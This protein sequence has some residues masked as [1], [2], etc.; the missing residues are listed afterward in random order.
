MSM[1][2]PESEGDDEPTLPNDSHGKLKKPKKKGAKTVQ[3][4]AA[5]TKNTNPLYNYPRSIQL[6]LLKIESHRRNPPI[7]SSSPH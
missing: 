4:I 2:Q 5:S 6:H 7:K 1:I 3:M